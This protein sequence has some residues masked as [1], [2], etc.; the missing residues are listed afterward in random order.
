MYRVLAANHEVRERRN[1]LRHL[2]YQKP[3][4]LSTGPNQ[5]WSWDITKLLGRA[6]WTYFY[7][8]VMLDIFSR[9]VVGRLLARGESAALAKALIEQSC[10]RQHIA[11][12][13]L[14]IHAGRGPAMT[15][16][17]V[18]LLLA[19]LGVLPSHSRPHV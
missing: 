15:S 16:K 13:Q 7:L 2:A 14:I 5:V 19:T 18:A 9:Y 10:Q 3:D 12:D 6:K 8:Y 17:P 1:Q 11:A 4:L